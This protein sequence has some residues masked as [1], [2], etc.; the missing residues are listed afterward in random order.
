[1][2]RRFAIILICIEIVLSVCFLVSGIMFVRSTSRMLPVSDLTMIQNTLRQ[3]ADVFDAQRDNIDRFGSQAIPSCAVNLRELSV[4][5]KDLAPAAELLRSST[6][7]KTPSVLGI[8]SIQPLR[9]LEDIAFDLE[10]LLP[11]LSRTLEQTANSFQD[12]TE[13]DH[14]LLIQSIDS[15][16]LLL[17]S[18]A[19]TLEIRISELPIQ[20]RRLGIIVCLGTLVMLLFAA[21]QFLLLPPREIRL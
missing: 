4:L 3:Y 13:H 2:R 14:R 16:I 21:T 15:T 6:T 1:M 11:R 19:D 17:R 7:M 10:L 18:C 12:Y 20:M 9:G 8:P 5:A